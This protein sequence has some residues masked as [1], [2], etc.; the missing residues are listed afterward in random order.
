MATRLAGGRRRARGRSRHHVSQGARRPVSGAGRH[1]PGAIRRRWRIGQGHCTQ[2]WSATSS[3]E[4]FGDLPGTWLRLHH[5]LGGP[6][7]RV[8]ISC[9]PSRATAISG[10]VGTARQFLHA[11]NWS[12]RQSGDVVH[13]AP[14]RIRE[15]RGRRGGRRRTRRKARVRSFKA[16][17]QIT[18]S[19]SLFNVAADAR[20]AL[21]DRSAGADL[22]RRRDDPRRR[23]DGPCRLRPPTTPG[24]RPRAG[25]VKLRDRITPGQL[26]LS[27]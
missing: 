26:H 1:G 24:R 16:G 22:S 4:T 19:Y 2:L 5:Q 20:E 21:V 9:A 8:L 11:A 6:A 13:R 27:A 25:S 12:R 15:G 17:R 3:E 23:S 10:R 14:G 18:Y 7:A